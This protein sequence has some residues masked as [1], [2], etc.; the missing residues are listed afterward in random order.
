MISKAKEWNETRKRRAAMKIFMKLYSDPQSTMQAI[1][2]EAA[3]KMAR[4]MFMRMLD[5]EGFAHCRM[6]P[7]R[8]PLK[9][10]LET[11]TMMC[12]LHHK[13]A[14]EAHEALKNPTRQQEDSPNGKPD[15]GSKAGIKTKV[16]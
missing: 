3:I 4:E 7:T 8:G 5:M 1:L 15:A 9:K 2:N 6:C 16:I 11:G 10:L 14:M 13:K 12:E